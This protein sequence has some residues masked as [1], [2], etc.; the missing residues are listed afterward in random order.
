MILTTR[1]IYIGILT[2]LLRSWSKITDSQKM[3][4]V[5]RKNRMYGHH[6]S[7]NNH[8]RE[9]FK[10]AAASEC[11][12]SGTQLSQY[13]YFR[14]PL[15]TVTQCVDRIPPVSPDLV[16][17]ATDF[18]GSPCRSPTLTSS[19]SE[20]PTSQKSNKIS[21]TISSASCVHFSGF[22]F[23][24]IAAI[25]PNRLGQVDQCQFWANRRHDHPQ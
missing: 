3:K 19:S 11:E 22:Y 9:G 12:K 18:H 8:S 21:R 16:S 14:A 5:T 7:Y 24:S 25:L 15:T 10:V 1:G 13:L 23:L 6:V 4:F 20:L 17:P 2:T